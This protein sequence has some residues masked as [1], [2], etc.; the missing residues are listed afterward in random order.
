MAATPPIS[1]ALV[2]ALL[3]KVAESPQ[4]LSRWRFPLAD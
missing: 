1:A 4:S 2:P 3:S